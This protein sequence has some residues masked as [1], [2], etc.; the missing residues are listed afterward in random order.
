MEGEKT[1]IEYRDAVAVVTMDNPDTMNAMDHEMGPALAGALEEVWRREEVRAV[2]LTGAGGNFSAGGN[3]KR[4]GEHLTQNPGSGASKVFAGYTHWV[5]RVAVALSKMPK[6]VICAVEGGCSGAGIAWLLASDFV[7][8]SEKAK[9]IPGFVYAGLVPAAGSSWH[10]PHLA[11]L[12]SASQTFMTNHRIPPRECLETGLCH[13][14]APAGKVLD[15]ALALAARL[16]RNPEA[17]I[18]A[19]KRLLSLA[20]RDGLYP[21]LE[22]ERREVL[23]AADTKEFRRRVE[24]FAAGS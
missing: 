15:A 8:M 2:I 5:H 6:P 18:A 17:A 22:N 13:E 9:L 24:A 20:L 10:M 7:V 14:L 16:T 19:T 21:H 11:G 12:Q 4:A 1:R 23:K 3:L